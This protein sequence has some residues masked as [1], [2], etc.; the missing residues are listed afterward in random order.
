MSLTAMVLAAGKGTRMKSEQAKV[1][2][3][4][5]GSPLVSWMYEIAV[6]AGADSIVAVVGHQADAV[7][8]ALPDDVATVEQTE[9]LGTGHA[10]KV[11]MKAVTAS[12]GDI[13]LVL[14]GDMPL[15]RA[16]TLRRLV[17]HHHDSARS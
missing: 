16:E 11:G 13:V 3:E 15:I 1:L 17:A 4:A 8:A 2:A 7:I 10:A 9:Q 6:R 5:A 12:P 14:P